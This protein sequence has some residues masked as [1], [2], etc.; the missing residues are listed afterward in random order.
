MTER[1]TKKMINS[2]E[3][4]AAEYIA[5]CGDHLAA[6]EDF[7]LAIEDGRTGA[8]AEALTAVLSPL[9]HLKGTALL[10]D[11][12]KVYELVCEFEAVFNRIRDG[13]L[14]VNAGV[15]T[16]LLRTA[17]HLNEMIQRGGTLD[18]DATSE[19]RALLRGLSA[20]PATPPG[21]LSRIPPVASRR[22]GGLR[23][24]LAEDD[25][26]SRL[27]MQT[28]LS[29]YGICHVAANGREAVDAFSAARSRREPYDLI[30]M[31]IMMPEMDGREAVR[32]MRLIEEAEGIRS[33]CGARIVMTTT[34]DDLKEVSRCFRELCDAYLVK[35]ID[36]G[37]LLATM[38]SFE[39]VA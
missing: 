8:G 4:L 34:L 28:F 14:S 16:T 25:G 19:L 37:R 11:F 10:L 2:E 36:L 18:V 12:A 1:E 31:D 15:V 17:D 22:P 30:C 7:L 33:T 6:V 26:A 29:G 27:M 35:P 32:R 38:K 13:G 3:K 9:H 39:L 23:T 24:M 20:S 5:Q 21:N